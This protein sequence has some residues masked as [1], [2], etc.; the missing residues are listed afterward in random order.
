M[1]S[2]INVIQRT[3]N[4]IVE[5]SSGSVS[6]INAGPAGPSGPQGPGGGPVGPQGPAGPTGPEGPMGPGGPQGT[7]GVGVPSG[8][9][10]EQVLAKASNGDYVTVWKTITPIVVKATEP[11]AADYGLTTIP[12]GAVWIQGA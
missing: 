4:I 11:T 6:V 8:G 10:D 5:P 9:L 1:S 12:V 3:Q 7:A 2:E